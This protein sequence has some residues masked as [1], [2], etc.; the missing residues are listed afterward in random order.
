MTPVIVNDASCLI[1]LRK[2][3]LLEVLGELPYRLVVPLPI[4]MLEVL[5]FSRREWC[6]LDDAG[7]ITHDLTAA[8]VEQ[9][10]HFKDR[11]PGLS[12]NDCFCLVTGLAYG[13]IVLTGD[14]ALRKAASGR[15]LRAHGV[16]WVVDEL[17]S[18]EVCPVSL[19]VAALR[20]WRDDAT[21]FLP[22]HEI[23][24]RLKSLLERR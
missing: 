5:D 13:G 9:A 21:V 20:L 14:A 10:F 23:S 17:A 24:M 11:H 6:L 1:D 22:R 16:L 8:E 3:R 18:A 4:R 7:M 12:P 19:L 15:G 2:G